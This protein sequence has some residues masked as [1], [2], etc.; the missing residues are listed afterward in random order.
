ML[1]SMPSP[2]TLFSCLVILLS[3][4]VIFAAGW[5]S[6]YL[7]YVNRLYTYEVLDEKTLDFPPD[8]KVDVR[9][10]ME[11]VGLGILNTDTS[12]V[13]W[14]DRGQKIILYKAQRGFQRSAPYVEK[15][16]TSYHALQWDD[17]TYRY[18]LEIEPLPLPPPKPSKSN[19]SK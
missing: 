15:V 11:F 2:K 19:T 13:E 12:V 3:V 14:D 5:G 18:H 8:S 4:A 10:V 6:A 16:E 1:S 9:H 17:G 7:R